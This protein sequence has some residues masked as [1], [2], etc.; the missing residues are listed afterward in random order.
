[1][2]SKRDF[3][4]WG[5]GLFAGLL[6][7]LL[8]APLNFFLGSS[9]FEFTI[10]AGGSLLFCLLIVYDTYRIM[11]HCSA[12]DYVVACVDLYLDILNLFVY[13][14]RV[15]RSFFLGSSLF[16]FTIAAGGSLL[17][18]LLIVYD[19]YRIMHHC[20]AEDYVVACVDLYLDILNLFVYLLRVLR[21]VEAQ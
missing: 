13:L 9:L 19:T 11:H 5:A 14:L 7:L 3:S 6:I 17:F 10:A 20:S 21:S 12:E 8:A 18:C 4:Q 15:L 1:M 2:Q 16:E